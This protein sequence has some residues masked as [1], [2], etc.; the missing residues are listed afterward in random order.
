MQE[1]KRAKR[2]AANEAVF[3]GVNERIEDLNRAV[4]SFGSNTMLVVCECGDINC[5]ERL[6]VPLERYER[7]RSDPALFLVARGHEEA[8]VEEVVERTEDYDVV[9]KHPGEP[10]RLA[11]DSDPRSGSGAG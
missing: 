6:E 11:A 1:R 5:T 9:R 10:E 3:R 8:E 2:I 7:V 4:A